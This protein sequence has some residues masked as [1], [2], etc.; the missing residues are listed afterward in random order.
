M[1]TTPLTLASYSRR[2]R[3]DLL[4]LIDEQ[5]RIHIHLDWHTVEDFLDEPGGLTWLAWHA[6]T[7]IGA[8]AVAPPLAGTTWIRLAVVHDSADAGQ[9]LCELWPPILE[10][11]R[12]L[13]TRELGLLIQRP[14]LAE[15][16]AIFGLTYRER[17][18]SLQRFSNKWPPP[19]RSD[20]TIRHGDLQDLD[21]VLAIDHAA[22]DPI[23]QL[24]RA[25]LREAIRQSASFTLALEGKTR[26]PIGYLIGTLYATGGHL[27]R[28][29][30]LPAW[31]GQGVGGVLLGEMLQT[32]ARRRVF[33]VSVN[34][35]ESNH[36]SLQLYQRFGF[37]FAGPDIPVWN[38]SLA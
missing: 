38:V 31:Q 32:F 9:T 37:T 14:W 29:A 27:A 11:L 3:R 15:Y 34:T 2:D 8:L 30:T 23:W 16:T 33:R 17:I 24:S 25:S 7:L 5:Y 22:F 1:L 35:Q 18:V 20:L 28:L 12:A 10:R 36:A 19:I 13:G 26:E 21:T 6:D 4:R